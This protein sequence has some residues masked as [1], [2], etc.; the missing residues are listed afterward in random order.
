MSVHLDELHGWYVVELQGRSLPMRFSHQDLDGS[1]V[2]DDVTYPDDFDC[3]R[4]PFPRPAMHR[5]RDDSRVVD[6]PLSYR[7]AL[8]LAYGRNQESGYRPSF[9]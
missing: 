8:S 6:G 5:L 1:F 7:E 4:W 2:F 9:R 3:G